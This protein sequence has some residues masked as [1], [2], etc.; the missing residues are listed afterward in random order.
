MTDNCNSLITY[1][2][3][4][5]SEIIEPGDVVMLNTADL[6]I[7]KAFYEDNKIT[8]SRFIL[9]VCVESNNTLNLTKIID[10]NKAKDVPRTVLDGGNATSVQSIII[11]GQGAGV[12]PKS[13]IT[14]AYKGIAK[15][16]VCESVKLGDKLTI[17]KYPGKVQ[18]YH[19]R[20]TDNL[21]RPIGK[22][23]ETVKDENYVYVLLDIE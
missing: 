4:N 23:I 6:K 21:T 16:N 15:V 10:G 9:G 17:S 7:T 20:Q 2:K 19:G 11:N 5:P 13:I 12:N 18:A 14:I 3:S 8:Y 22:V 1:T